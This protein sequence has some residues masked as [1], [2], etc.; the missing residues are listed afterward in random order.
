MVAPPSCA[1]WHRGVGL[2][3]GNCF[4]SKCQ[5]CFDVLASLHKSILWIVEM[6]FLHE[7]F[8]LFYF[9]C[10]AWFRALETRTWSVH[11][12][13]NF[14][15]FMPWFSVFLFVELNCFQCDL[16]RWRIHCCHCGGVWMGNE[17][18]FTSTHVMLTF[19]DFTGSFQET[20]LIIT[21]LFLF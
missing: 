7:F 9:F 11:L 14:P 12:K 2:D 3:L 6:S 13:K 8:L 1:W 5:G 18:L 15:V 17:P 20:I 10:R 21:A 4:V 16:L 19:S